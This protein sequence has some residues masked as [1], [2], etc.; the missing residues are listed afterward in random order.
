MKNFRV[1]V[2]DK[3]GKN[4][5]EI[6]DQNTVPSQGDFVKHPDS[7]IYGIV[8]YVRW[9]YNTGEVEVFLKEEEDMIT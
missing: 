1:F 3:T 2:H 6:P 9:N 7:H 5:I 8:D 4:L